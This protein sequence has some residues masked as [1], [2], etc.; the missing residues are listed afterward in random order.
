[1]VLPEGYL[2]VDVRV[3]AQGYSGAQV[4]DV[5]PGPD[6]RA[7]SVPS[8]TRLTG[9]LVNDGRPVPGLRVAVVQT[10]RG[11]GHLFIKAVGAVTDAD[12]RFAMDR[13]PA[14]D[15]YAIFT[16]VGAGPQPFVITTKK[17]K[18]HGDR[19]SRDLGDLGVIPARR[20]AGLIDVPSGQSL[21]AN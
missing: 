14:N 2:S 3:T 7:I 18:A 1:M 19:Q 21:P 8:G 12:G 20:I 4:A 13:L 10:D 17:F 5:K 16:L 6:R 9:R 11:V 15:E